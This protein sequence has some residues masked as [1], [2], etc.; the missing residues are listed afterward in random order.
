MNAP[1]ISVKEKD[2][3]VLAYANGFTLWHYQSADAPLP[4]NA[5]N[6]VATVVRPGDVV[7]VSHAQNGVS[8]TSLLVVSA[9]EADAVTMA[10]LCG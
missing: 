6:A 8:T 10:S 9:V 3:N 2:L 7:L 4:H 5:F 1:K